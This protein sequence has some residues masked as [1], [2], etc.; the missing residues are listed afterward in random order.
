MISLLWL[1]KYFKFS[2]PPRGLPT[3]QDSL[4]CLLKWMTLTSATQDGVAWSESVRCYSHKLSKNTD[5][6]KL[7]NNQTNNNYWTFSMMLTKSHHF[8]FKIFLE[9]L[10]YCTKYNP[11]NGTIHH[12]LLISCQDCMKNIVRKR[13]N[14]DF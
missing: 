8:R 12:K 5:N 2:N 13:K 6:F 1:N 14:Y 4:S 9:Q 10:G 11:V 3:D 7:A